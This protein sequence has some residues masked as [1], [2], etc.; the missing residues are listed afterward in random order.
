[1]TVQVYTSTARA[2]AHHEATGPR[3]TRAGRPAIA[4][5]AGDLMQ[6]RSTWPRFPVRRVVARIRDGSSLP[7]IV[8]TSGGRFVTK[9]RGAAQGPS[10][11]VAE[12]VVAELATRLGLPVPERALMELERPIQTDDHND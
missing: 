11:L 5:F 3:E 7:V 2:L 12:V 6:A 8:D 4:V 10:A 1:M 9:L